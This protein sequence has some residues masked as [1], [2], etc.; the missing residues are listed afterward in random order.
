MSGRLVSYYAGIEKL[1][2]FRPNAI[3]LF[4]ALVPERTY[5]VVSGSAG[6]VVFLAVD[7][8]LVIYQTDPNP[9]DPRKPGFFGFGLYQSEVEYRDLKLYRPQLR[10]VAA[11]Y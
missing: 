10:P 11:G 5:H 3:G 9:P 1:P 4:Q 8:E 7:G 6:G 2:T